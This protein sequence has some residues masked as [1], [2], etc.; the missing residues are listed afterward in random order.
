MQ[1]MMIA[2]FH[3]HLIDSILK[4]PIHSNV[5]HVCQRKICQLPHFI[6]D[7]QQISPINF[8][9]IKFV[10]CTYVYVWFVKQYFTLFM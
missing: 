10:I 5:R 8:E 1:S 3:E 6:P 2:Y 7:T 9:T 4:I